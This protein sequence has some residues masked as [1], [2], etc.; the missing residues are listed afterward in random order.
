MPIRITGEH[1]KFVGNLKVYSREL[2][3]Y[4]LSTCLNIEQ[5]HISYNS[6]NI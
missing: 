6:D 4:E 2:C 5:I 1:V 3:K